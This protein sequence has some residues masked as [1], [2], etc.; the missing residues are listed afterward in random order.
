MTKAELR[1]KWGV[2]TNTDKLVDDIMALLTEYSH[3]NTEHGVCKILDTYFTNK[4][5]LIRLLKG[6]DGFDDN[7]RLVITK[8][9]DRITDMG[10][11]Q[12]FLYHFRNQIIKSEIMISR[13]DKDGKTAMDYL[14]TGVRMFNI[15]Q[16]ANREFAKKLRD[17]EHHMNEFD[18][19]GQLKESVA[20]QNKW[21]DT[22]YVFDHISSSTLSEERAQEICKKADSK[23]YTAGLKTSRAFNRVCE[24]FGVTKYQDYDK[25]FAK[26]ADMVSGGTRKLDFVVSLNPY[27][28]L[29]MSFGNSWSS[30]HTIDKR[31]RRGM[32]NS[33]SG[34]YCGGTLSYMLDEYNSD[35]STGIMSVNR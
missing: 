15:N 28:Y 31:N 29:T 27:D 7:L 19:N 11:I 33:Y 34:Q 35:T 25:L 9:F 3:R 26:Y 14:T 12:T 10:T 22:A 16:L 13:V 23:K 2:Y 5:P 4:A 18:N 1:E 17:I 6:V 20:R 24:Q 21:L 32:P 30:C 8:D